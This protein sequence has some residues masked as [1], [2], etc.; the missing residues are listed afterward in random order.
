MITVFNQKASNKSL[1]GFCFGHFGLCFHLIDG[2][3]DCIDGLIS[4]R[5]W[6]QEP[7][8]SIS[9]LIVVPSP[10]FLRKSESFKF[11]KA[12]E[13]HASSRSSLASSLASCVSEFTCHC[14]DWKTTRVLWR[15]QHVELR[16]LL[17]NVWVTFVNFVLWILIFHRVAFFFQGK[18]RNVCWISAFLQSLI[19]FLALSSLNT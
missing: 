19:R 4:R 10:A 1:F 7:I 6:L 16:S 15:H 12:P 5:K 9:L 8:S 17:E 13:L 18:I 3:R 2:H 14:M 11:R